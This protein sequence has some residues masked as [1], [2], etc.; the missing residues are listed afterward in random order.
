MRRAPT[1]SDIFAA[2]CKLEQS[3]G[4]TVESFRRLRSALRSRLAQP[5]SV[6]LAVGLAALIG[7]WLVRRNKPQTTR[8]GNGTSSITGLAIG[9]LIRF[10]W[11]RFSGFLRDSSASPQ[12]HSATG[13]LS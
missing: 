9:F 4:D 3:R 7:F 8:A 13:V 2:E 1:R 5:S 12:K 6:A 10:G 11:H